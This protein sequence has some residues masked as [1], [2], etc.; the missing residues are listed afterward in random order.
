MHELV[1]PPCLVPFGPGDHIFV[2]LS[3]VLW[4]EIKDVKKGVVVEHVD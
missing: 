4:I 3:D 1:P 2:C